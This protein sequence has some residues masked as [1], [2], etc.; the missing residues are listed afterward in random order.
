M[1]RHGNQNLGQNNHISQP[2]LNMNGST[3][4]SSADNGFQPVSVP[5]N[6]YQS[7]QC[8][9]HPARQVTCPPG[10]ATQVYKRP[11]QPGKIKTEVANCSSESSSEEKI[12]GHKRNV[13]V[14]DFMQ[15][16]NTL[17]EDD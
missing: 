7:H 3:R 9:H 1:N 17:R 2:S 15:L 5:P 16:I 11:S 6:P 4:C 13:S 12:D 14:D 8:C 10:E